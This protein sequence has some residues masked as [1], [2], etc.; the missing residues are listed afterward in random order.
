MA[1]RKR[2]TK[3]ASLVC[4]GDLNS[5]IKIIDRKIT[6][7][8]I[9]FTM[10][11]SDYVEAWSSIETRRGSTRFDGVNVNREADT[12]IFRIRYGYDVAKKQLIDWNGTYFEI[13]RIEDLN[14]ERRFLELSCVETGFKKDT[15]GTTDLEANWSR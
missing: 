6:P 3:K 12:T 14:G 11:L 5:L 1:C 15:D 13:D 7:D 2:I 8:T 10:N 4:T 9:S